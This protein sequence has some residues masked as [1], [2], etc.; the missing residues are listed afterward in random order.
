MSNLIQNFLLSLIGMFLIHWFFDSRT[1]WKDLSKKYKTKKPLPNTFITSQG[2]VYMNK[3]SIKGLCIG[4]SG[5][6]LFLSFPPPPIDF[7]FP[8][9]LI[10]WNEIAYGQIIN[11][12]SRAGYFIFELGNPK[13]TGLQ[14]SSSYIE[15]IHEE[16]GEAIFFERLG[17]PN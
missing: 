15:K 12:N 4:V 5:E 17:T 16:Y 13:I 1:G 9:L 14:I 2:G 3:V 6:G 8:S 10:P 7:V 11:S